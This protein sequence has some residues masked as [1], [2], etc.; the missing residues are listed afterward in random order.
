MRTGNCSWYAIYGGFRT[1]VLMLG[2]LLAIT[3]MMLFSSA[4]TND[5]TAVHDVLVGVV[6]LS[7]FARQ[8]TLSN[9]YLN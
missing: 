8:E 2:F 1:T 9:V 5:K 4:E 6:H 3:R 7:K